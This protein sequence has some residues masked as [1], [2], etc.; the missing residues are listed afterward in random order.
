MASPDNR[1]GAPQPSGASGST[2]T[3]GIMQGATSAVSDIAQQA[4]TRVREQASQV[5]GQA[6]EHAQAFLS[7]Q[8]EVA[9]DHIEGVAKVLHDTVDQLRQ[10]SPG[11]VTDYAERAVG[12]LDSVANALREQDLGALVGQVEDFARRQPVLFL[13]GSVAIGFALARFLKSSSRSSQSTY[14]HASS[15]QFGGESYGFPSDTQRPSSSGA[16][17]GGTRT[18]YG[19]HMDTERQNTER[20]NTRAGTS[21]GGGVASGARPSGGESR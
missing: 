21:T 14:G 5:A 1:P 3:S 9:A 4:G 8:K 10:R 17:G 16:G 12:S 11:A 7:G 15:R 18:E 20:Q 2:S 19:R 13:A 6:Q